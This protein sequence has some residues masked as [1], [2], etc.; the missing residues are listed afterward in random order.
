MTDWQNGFAQAENNQAKAQKQIDT[1]LSNVGKTNSK[2]VY[3]RDSKIDARP[4]RNYANPNKSYKMQY[5]KGEY[6]EGKGMNYANDRGSR[7]RGGRG[8]NFE[9]NEEGRDGEFKVRPRGRGGDRGGRGNY[10][11]G[12]R[13]RGEFRGGRGNYRKPRDNQSD[14]DEDVLS[15]DQV[16]FIEKMKKECKGRG[17]CLIKIS[18]SFKI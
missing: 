9:S 17:V 18:L 12:E 8:R 14:E 1:E 11:G 15:E 13:G 7:P 10:R 3:S 5:N 6:V 16:Q 2:E 4:A